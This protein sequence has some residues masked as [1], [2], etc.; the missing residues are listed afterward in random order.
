MYAFQRTD[1]LDTLAEA[2]RDRHAILFVGAG[3]SMCLGLP[4]WRGLIEHMGKEL[5]RDPVSFADSETDYRTLAEYYRLKKRGLG[6]LTCWM[7]ENW[8]ATEDRL[9][10]SEAHRLIVELDFPII[11]TTNYDHNLE[12]ALCAFGKDFV[13]ITSVRDIAKIRNGL[14]QI[15]KFHGDV[16]DGDSLVIGE[17]DYFDRLRFESPLDIKLRAD[18]LGRTI[19]FVGYSLSDLNIRLLLHRLW[20]TWAESG[21]KHDRPR[22][23]VFMPQPSS[24]EETVLGHWG[25]TVVTE[26]AESPERALTNF[27]RKLKERVEAG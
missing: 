26:E 16:D 6:D 25:L 18:A 8:N 12:D 23:F 10:E 1:M 7:A 2:V 20:R 19:L 3:L 27:L 9:R 15:V 24:V 13:R 22:S 11:Y 4:S 17:T 14:T 5:G 21:A